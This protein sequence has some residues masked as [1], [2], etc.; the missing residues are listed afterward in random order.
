MINIEETGSF[1]ETTKVYQ[2]HSASGK[3]RPGKHKPE[4][5]WNVMKTS[6]STLSWLVFIP[7]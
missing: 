6:D 2:F 5:L 3:I 1:S 7:G 4:I